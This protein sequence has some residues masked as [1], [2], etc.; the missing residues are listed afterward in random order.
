MKRT[1]YKGFEI[2]KVTSRDYLIYK[3]GELFADLNKGIKVYSYNTNAKTLKEAKMRIE[4]Y[5]A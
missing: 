3:N 2:E 4:F 1:N 5:L